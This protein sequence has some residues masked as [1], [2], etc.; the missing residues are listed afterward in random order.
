VPSGRYPTVVVRPSIRARGIFAED[1]EAE[2]WFSDDARRILAHL[3]TK[4]AEF[5]LSV[6]LTEL[7]PGGP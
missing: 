3:K 1:G 5:S 7:R 6:S 2:L 4:L